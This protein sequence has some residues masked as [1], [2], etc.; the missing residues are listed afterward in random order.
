MAEARKRRELLPLIYHHLLRAGY[1]RAAREV[2][3]Q[4]GQK[5]FLAQ[6]VTLLDIYTH[7]Q[8][9][10]ELGR[11]RK[12]EEDA[13]LQAKKTRVSDPISTSESSEEEEEAEAE[14]AKATPRLAS[15][16]SSVLGA[17]LPSSMKEKAK[18]E[19]EKAGKTGNSMPHPAT[20][21]TVANLLSGKSPRKSA[22]PSA[23]TTLVSETEEEGSVPA[24]GAAAK[25]GMVSAGQ[26][27]SSSED[28]SSSSDETDVEVK[29]SEKILQV[30]AASA[31][32]K[33]TPGKGATPAPP[34]KAGAVASQTKAGKP[35]EDSESSS[36]ESSD[37]EEETPAAKALLQAKASGKTSQV[38]AASAP[39]K[40]SPRKGAA[41]APPGKTGPAVAKAQAGKRE[42]DSQSSSEES[43]SEEEAPAQAKP[44]GKAPQVRAASAPAKE[45]PRKGA[46]PAPPR[47]T[48]PAA[49]QVQVG[50]QEEDSRSS[51]E[52][53]D[54]DREALAAMNAAQVKP[55]GKSP[56]VK[57]ASTMGMGPLGK[58]AGPVPP[59]KVGPATPSAQVGK[60]EEDSESSSEE[61]SDSSD[62]EVPTA[63]APAQEKSLGNILQAKPTS[64]PAKGPP[65]KAGPVAV[66]VKAEKPMDNSE[67]SEESS[68]SADSEEAPAA[69]TAAQAKPAL[70][71]PQTKACP[72]KTN[73]TASAKVAPVRVG[74]QAPR[75]AGTA[76]S[77]AG[78]SPA[79]AGGT[80][81]PAEDSSS[82]EESDSEE[83]KTG[84][85][86]TVG[87]AK[88]VG[89]GLQVKAAS[90]PVKGSLGQ[91]TAPVLPGKTGPTVTQVK[92][93]KQEDSESSEEE[94]DS[95]EAAA[96]PAQVK[97]SVKKTQAKA[98]PA[99]ARA[100]SA[101]GTI[102]APGK[103][104]TAAAQAKQRSPSK[105]K[106]SGKTHQI[107]AALAPA[108]ESPRKG[109]A[110]TPPGKTGPSA[111]QA[112]KQDDSGSSS[113]ESD[114][115]G[116]AP[117]AVTSAQVIKP[118]LIFVD[119][120]RS[121]AGPAATPAQAQ[122]ASTPRKARA[123]ESTA[124]SSSS[125]SEDEDV[126]PATQCLT[127]GIRT[128]VV[129]MPT[130]HPR[131]APKASMA[132]ASSSKE[133]SRISDGKKQEG[134]A[135]QV[136]SAVGTLPATSPQST[137]VQA[138]GT[139]K[140]RKP[141]LPEVQQATKAPESSDDSED[142]SDSSSGSEED[143]EGPQGAKSAHTLG[144]TPSR[145][146]TLVE[147]TAAESSE[148]DVVAPSQSLLSG[149]MTPG[150]TPANSQASKATPKLDSSPSVSSTLAAKDDPDGKQ[151][152]K[153]QQ[154]A[155]MLSPKTGGKEAAS[156]TTPQKSRKPK[157]GAGNPQ[158]STLALQ[159]NITQ[160]LL[161]QPWPL[162]EAQVQASVVKVLTELLEQERKKVVDTTKESSRK[163]W[164]SRKRK[165]S[166]DQPA[167]RTPRS[168]KKKK[169][170]AGE[171]GEASVSPEKTSTTSKG[172]AK[173]DKASGDVK[174]KK[175][176]GSL[177]SQGA[178]DEPEEELQKGMGTVEGGDQ[179]NPKSKKEKKK[180][181]KRKKDKEKKEKKKKAKKA[182]TKDSES[183]SQKKK[184]KKKKTAEQTV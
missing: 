30:R 39:A 142:S 139:N 67:S 147:E 65:Q 18:A 76:T 35:E 77:P 134:P 15:T 78:S 85:A 52:E 88:S 37:S 160:C 23:N 124:R 99:A 158:A 127:P 130:A 89:K 169:L 1:V 90:V 63:V 3:E 87:Q 46:A 22:E 10:S 174:E 42:E 84:L 50:K 110:P 175:G 138:K 170:G 126:I 72:K 53:S 140:L 57:P 34:G 129:T 73:T 107:R 152:A 141:K 11:K 103:V 132:G 75:K 82:S 64:S 112:G 40:E 95:E 44:S 96:S 115:D 172:K 180:S 118:P 32:A 168:K 101:K 47:K 33:G 20:G 68:D 181:D 83:E 159:S 49:A 55:L 93:E 148:D 8:Q 162:N 182:S 97:T 100:P 14:T 61:S 28:T 27:D 45:S 48:G 150:L 58:G 133:S 153:P 143:G 135:T 178:K 122:A 13:A 91:G 179:S 128:N 125:E 146:E 5:C 183:P 102:S 114:S 171:G 24:F 16:N 151:E 43:D 29:A 51:S 109:A 98:N 17:D 79:V 137:S 38:G 165:L 131:I 19:T 59:G 54:S 71:I 80:Q 173:R 56:Q 25:P 163:G 120:N 161:G 157:K 66:Q 149:Y 21:K 26:A 106:P 154:A 167:A 69:M 60:W 94:S 4:S 31:P 12:A 7:W 9:T 70:K 119:P 81:R 41:P 116:E 104:V 155:G 6:P 111:A 136:D 176:K 177:G 144:P 62:G 74:T 2:K 156:G 92:A 123:S 121:P 105:V 113:E 108:K 145:T 86:V 166:G 117:A 36:E 164:E 184:K